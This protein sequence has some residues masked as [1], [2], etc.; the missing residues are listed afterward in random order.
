ML[1]LDPHTAFAVLLEPEEATA[2]L[3]HDEAREDREYLA[4]NTYREHVDEFA[5][6]KHRHDPHPALVI[7]WDP[8]RERI[9]AITSIHGGMPDN[10]ELHQLAL[11]LP[12]TPASIQHLLKLMEPYVD[13]RDQRGGL[14]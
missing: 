10:D 9:H 12:E 8:T 13:P 2:Y 11:T 3:P 1:A 5:R 6:P 4:I 14:A 7:T